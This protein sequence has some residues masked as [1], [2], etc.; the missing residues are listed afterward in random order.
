MFFFFF[1]KHDRIT[2]ACININ[3]FFQRHQRSTEQNYHLIPT[4]T[5]FGKENTP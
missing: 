3:L 4:R 5:N 2:Y 1:V